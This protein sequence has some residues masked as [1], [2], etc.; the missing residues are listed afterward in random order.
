MFNTGMTAAEFARYIS[1]AKE[2]ST[3][4]LFHAIRDI[5]D[6][7]DTWATSGERHPREGWYADEMHTYSDELRRR[8]LA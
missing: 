3:A 8:Q 4:S 2:M 6:T 5:R 7:I 1:K